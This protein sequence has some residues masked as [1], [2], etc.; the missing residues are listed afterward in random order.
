MLDNAIMERVMHMLLHDGSFGIVNPNDLVEVRARANYLLNH[1][2]NLHQFGV[3][4]CSLYSSFGYV[5]GFM[6]I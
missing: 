2:W 6:T 5:P 4:V 1:D 3:E